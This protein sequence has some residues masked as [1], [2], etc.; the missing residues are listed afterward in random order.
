MTKSKPSAK[1]EDLGL[2]VDTTAGGAGA[3][4][5]SCIGQE[6]R[7]FR[8]RLNLKGVEL[9]KLSG[10]TPGALSKIEN[11]QVS[12]SLATL[13]AIAQALSVPVTALF[14]RFEEQHAA[15]HVPA[16]KGLLIERRGTRV[17]HLYHLLGHSTDKRVAFEPYLI[18]L[19][20]ESEVFP[21]FQHTGTEFLYMLEGEVVYRHGDKTYRLRP[22]DSLLFDAIAPHGPDEL[23][24]LPARYLSIIAYT[25]DDD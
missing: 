18:T 17:G 20:E 2:L 7:N 23:I 5:E 13:Q 22:G 1:A 15:S 10:L 8:R 21:L 25:R 6:V 9:A 14:R 16:G 11:G 19:T 4:L 12:P 24:S 3:D